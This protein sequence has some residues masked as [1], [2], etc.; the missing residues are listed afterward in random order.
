MDQD[1]EAIGRTAAN[2]ILNRIED[3]LSP[4]ASVVYP[5]HLRVRKSSDTPHPGAMIRSATQEPV[6]VVS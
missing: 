2:L 4:T 3:P 6:L 1:F 5:A